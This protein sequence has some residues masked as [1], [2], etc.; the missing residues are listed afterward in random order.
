MQMRNFF[1]SVT[2]AIVSV[3]LLLPITA[4][5]AD[6]TWRFFR[7]YET[8][9]GSVFLLFGTPDILRIE[10]RY[11]DIKRTPDPGVSVRFTY[12]GLEYS[13]FRGDLRILKG[14]L[15]EA[16]SILVQI[17]DGKV[18]EVDWDYA[19]KYKPGA[20]ALWKSDKSLG[21][22]V[23]EYLTL[24]S[25]KLSDGNILY[26]TCTTGRDGSCDGP[27]KAMLFKDQGTK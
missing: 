27:I 15:G 18:V 25:K 6:D 9:E 12:Y 4:S 3:A 23:G 19:V 26:V 16:S 20:E 5:A 13:R 7:P 14:P 24:G 17:Q 21:T 11:E 10:V 1:L 22:R 2:P 8:T